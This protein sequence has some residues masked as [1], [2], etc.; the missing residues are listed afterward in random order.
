[1]IPVVL[2]TRV[3]DASKWKGEVGLALSGTLYI[4]MCGDF[5]DANYF[6]SCINYLYDRIAAIT[7]KAKQ[8]KFK[9]KTE[10]SKVNA[11]NDNAK[12]GVDR[13][14]YAAYAEALYL[15][16]NAAALP[17]CVGLYAKWGSGKSF[18][19]QLLKRNFD[20][21]VYERKDDHELL[22]WFEEGY[23]DLVQQPKRKL[24]TNASDKLS[25]LKRCCYI[26]S[27]IWCFPLLCKLVFEWYTA[28]TLLSI[29]SD[30]VQ[31]IIPF[32]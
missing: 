32:L 6:E 19:I 18:M 29:V 12:G 25:Q 16:L 2:D 9:E 10:S 1:L 4:D 23:D 5:S 15:V 21:A 26:F 31:A 13:L 24:N 14:G 7:G 11:L 28:A 27:C 22:Q 30:T 3:R 20:R 17:V 8:Y